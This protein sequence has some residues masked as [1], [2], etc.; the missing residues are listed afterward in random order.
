M[1]SSGIFPE[2]I[3]SR[4]PFQNFCLQ[5]RSGKILFCK[6][7]LFSVNLFLFD[8]FMDISSVRV[9]SKLSKIACSMSQSGHSD[10]KI[11][12]STGKSPGI[13]FHFTEGAWLFCDKYYHGFPHCKYFTHL[14]HLLTSVKASCAFWVISSKFPAFISLSF[15]IQLPP[16]AAMK[17]FSR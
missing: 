8:K 3:Y 9:F 1:R 10:R 14:P 7:N 5:I 2:I 13:I 12:L 16:H 6:K 4:I 11:Q 15:T 17:G